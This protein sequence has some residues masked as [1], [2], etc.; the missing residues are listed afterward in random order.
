[1]WWSWLGCGAPPDPDACGPSACARGESPSASGA[2]AQ[3]ELA[4]DIHPA[5][6]RLGVRGQRTMPELSM[7]YGSSAS[8]S[9]ITV[10]PG[11]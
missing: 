9:S 5:R 3:R 11:P 4:A 2:P 10:D 8:S 6:H 7:P 1:M